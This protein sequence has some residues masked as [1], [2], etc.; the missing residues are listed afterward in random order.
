M[1]ETKKKLNP[2]A[3][4]WQRQLGI[5]DNPN[6]KREVADMSDPAFAVQNLLGLVEPEHA[7]HRSRVEA[8]P[9]QSANSSGGMNPIAEFWQRQFGMLPPEETQAQYEESKANR[10]APARTVQQFLGESDSPERTNEVVNMTGPAFAIQ[11]LLGLISPEQDAARR[12]ASGS[13]K[14][15][16]KTNETRNVRTA[17]PSNAIEPAPRNATDGPGSSYGLDPGKAT[18]ER[19]R[20][21]LNKPGSVG[22][23][24]LSERRS[25]DGFE[26]EPTPT[27]PLEDEV[28]GSYNRYGE[29]LDEMSSVYANL[30]DKNMGE[31][32]NIF[33]EVAGT[34]RAG[35]APLI[36]SYGQAHDNIGGIYDNLDTRLGGLASELQGIAEGA[37]GSATG[38]VASTSE[39]AIAPF[40]AASAAGR[41]NAQANV[42]Q[43]SNAGQRYLGSLADASTEEGKMHATRLQAAADQRQAEFDIKRMELELAREEAL[44]EVAMDTA[45]SAAE[46]EATAALFGAAGIELPPGLDMSQAGQ[47]VNIAQDL[48][49]IPSGSGGQTSETDQLE[50]SLSP[51]GSDFLNSAIR[52]AEQSWQTSSG[53]GVVT[54]DR[55]Q[56]FMFDVLAA[57]DDQ[58]AEAQA[59][60][61]VTPGQQHISDEEADMIRQ[62]IRNEYGKF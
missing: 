30:A 41:A 16:G 6:R 54:G 5:I 53:D 20:G 15:S 44:R 42:Q 27:N 50:A 34:A 1:A 14:R 9:V 33:S 25:M 47:Y 28:N 8:I 29:M 26:G 31:I 40:E 11:S 43:H 57:L 13:T 37:A 17:T 55:T 45:G 36:E 23:V 59:L 35:N 60:E 62:I 52:A 39:A 2:F 18:V 32:A 48:G 56:D 24:P 38:D 49:L 22:S 4:F 19:N 3:E 51:L 46:R 58:I 12:T 21:G 10:T 61:T 7:S